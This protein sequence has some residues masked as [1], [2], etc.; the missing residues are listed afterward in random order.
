[1]RLQAKQQKAAAVLHL[2][3][4]QS[5][6]S[7]RS[8]EGG[9][10]HGGHIQQ[11]QKLTMSRPLSTWY[12]RLADRPMCSAQQEAL[13]RM[14]GASFCT[15]GMVYWLVFGWI[16]WGPRARQRGDGRDE[17]QDGRSLAQQPNMRS[18]MQA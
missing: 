2:T 13:P 17:P 3:Q 14:D 8:A 5:V 15:V 4:R 6:P 7:A 12:R 11:A 18:T 9:L 1:M 16:G 10:D